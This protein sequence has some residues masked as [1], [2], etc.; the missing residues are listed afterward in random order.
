MNCWVMAMGFR[1]SA[2][3]VRIVV[4]VSVHIKIS[5]IKIDKK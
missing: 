4:R 2:A 5:L 3:L 1:L